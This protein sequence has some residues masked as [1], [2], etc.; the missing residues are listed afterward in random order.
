MKP[1]SQSANTPAFL[2]MAEPASSIVTS[3]FK[4][5]LPYFC[6]RVA[7]T[8]STKFDA[9]RGISILNLFFNLSISLKKIYLLII[10]EAATDKH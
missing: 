7:P 3:S 1:S 2:P 4:I 6:T 10:E 9:P 5:S 8:S